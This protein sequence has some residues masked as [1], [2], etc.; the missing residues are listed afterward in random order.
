M[1]IKIPDEDINKL[2]INLFNRGIFGYIP[3][4]LSEIVFGNTNDLIKETNNIIKLKSIFKDIYNIEATAGF[5]NS[6]LKQK[7]SIIQLFI[8]QGSK[9]AFETLNKLQKN[10]LPGKDK[11]F[12]CIV[13]ERG[14]LNTSLDC[15]NCVYSVPNFYATANIVS[16]VTNTLEHFKNAFNNT[17]F[18]TEKIKQVNLLFMELDI[19]DDIVNKLGEDVVLEFFEGSKQGYIKLLDLLNDVESEKSIHEYATYTPKGVEGT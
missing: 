6:V 2:S 8:N 16:S 7:E 18:E 15:K 1:Y 5:L 11:N 13:S 12:Q 17:N 4:I 3:K 9:V 14:C 19:L 10:Y